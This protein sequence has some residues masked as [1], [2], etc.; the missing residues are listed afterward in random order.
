MQHFCPECNRNYDC[1]IEFTKKCAATMPHGLPCGTPYSWR[2]P[3]CARKDT[4][5]CDRPTSFYTD[6][7]YTTSAVCL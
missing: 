4:L 7:A 5:L 2:C 6:F 3:D 1:Q